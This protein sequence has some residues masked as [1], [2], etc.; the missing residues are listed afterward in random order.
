MRTN[1]KLNQTLKCHH[2][3]LFSSPVGLFNYCS[4]LELEKTGKGRLETQVT[5]LREVVERQGKE[6]EGLRAREKAATEEAKKATKQWRE[7]RSL[8]SATVH[9]VPTVCQHLVGTPKG[10]SGLFFFYS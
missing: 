9:F 7:V 4:K 1:P 3:H 5:R 2:L 6:T 8:S 10:H